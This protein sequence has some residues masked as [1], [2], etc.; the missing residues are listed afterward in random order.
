VNADGTLVVAYNIKHGAHHEYIEVSRRG[1][2]RRWRGPSVVARGANTGG[3]EVATDARGETFLAWSAGAPDEEGGEVTVLILGRRGKPESRPHVLSPKSQTS[4]CVSLAVNP[5]GDAVVAWGQQLADGEGAGRIE[6]AT[7]IAGRGFTRPTRI[8]R[9][10]WARATITPQ[11]EAALLLQTET[12]RR[13]SVEASHTVEV[14][15]HPLR[16]V[17]SRPFRLS[18]K[19][20]AKPLLGSTARGDLIAV[21]EIAAPGWTPESPSYEFESAIR[22]TGGSWQALPLIVL[23]RLTGPEELDIA[24]NGGGN[25]VFI[26]SNEVLYAKRATRWVEVA[27]YAS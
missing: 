13:E 19:E 4:C 5:S 8:V 22:P 11:G 21:W 17:W 18:P 1:R 25:V 16:G 14:A 9:K 23:S 3:P 27:T 10:S 26:W 6:V 2:D 15:T 7:R 12:P 20:G 24:V